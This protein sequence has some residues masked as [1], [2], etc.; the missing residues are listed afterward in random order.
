MPQQPLPAM[1]EQDIIV[2]AGSEWELCRVLHEGITGHVLKLKWGN[3]MLVVGLM[4][5]DNSPGDKEREQIAK[6]IV[7]RA[8]QLA[9]KEMK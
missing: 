1:F 7:M 9:Q 3:Q 6:W 4:N 8:A 5:N 2:I